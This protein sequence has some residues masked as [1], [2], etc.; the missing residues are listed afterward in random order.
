MGGWAVKAK[1][2]ITPRPVGTPCIMIPANLHKIF[3]NIEAQNES[4]R[5]RGA[6]SSVCLHGHIAALMRPT[7]VITYEVMI[8]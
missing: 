3:Q 5:F 7:V 1:G 2:R 4:A 6:R 8:N